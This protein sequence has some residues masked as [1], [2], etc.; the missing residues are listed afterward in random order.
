MEGKI[1]KKEPKMRR[2]HQTSSSEVAEDQ[3]LSS[4]PQCSPCSPISRPTSS[5][6]RNKKRITLGSQKN[7]A[8]NSTKDK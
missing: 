1:K 8:Q 7:V 5:P 4:E 3:P 6:L 2:G